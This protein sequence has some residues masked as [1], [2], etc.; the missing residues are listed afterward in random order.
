MCGKIC[1]KNT[2][3]SRRIKSIIVP[4]FLWIK[5]NIDP[6]P[7]GKREN[8]PHKKILPV[9]FKVTKLVASAK[10]RM[11]AECYLLPLCTLYAMYATIVDVGD[12]TVVPVT[13]THRTTFYMHA[14]CN[15]LLCVNASPCHFWSGVKSKQKLLDY[16]KVVH[17][18]RDQILY[19][20]T[21]F[22]TVVIQEDKML[23][24]QRRSAS[25]EERCTC[26]AR[27]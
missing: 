12:G 3:V 27:A 4:D 8:L 23:G 24:C 11:N 16:P 6:V 10:W 9:S 26:H 25:A 15:G 21:F 17:F 18:L 2:I 1:C 14:V 7:T 19:T 20:S 5:C 22:A 13:T